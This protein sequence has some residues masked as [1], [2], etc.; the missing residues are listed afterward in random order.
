MDDG[1][2][3][4]PKIGRPTK[5]KPEFVELARQ[6][7]EAGATDREIAGGLGIAPSTFYV[8][9]NMFP[10]FS[11]AV[12][13]GKEP[14]NDRV[15]RSL[16]DRANGYAYIEQQAVKV[17]DGKDEHGAL[18]ERVEIVDVERFIP[19]DTTSMIFWLKN[20]RPQQWRDKHEFLLPVEDYEQLDDDTLQ[21]EFLRVAGAV[22]AR[23]SAR[24][25]NRAPRAIEGSAREVSN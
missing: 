2:L 13:V 1:E 9:C 14:S 8:F 18:K 24:G 21:R 15:E 12:K 23:V 25:R 7:A 16:Y 20:R 4:E 6:Y 5:F 11:D 22:Q 17:K 19:P 10:E 3:A